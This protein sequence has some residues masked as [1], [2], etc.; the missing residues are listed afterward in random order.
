MTSRRHFLGGLMAAASLPRISWAELG[1]PAYLAAARHA[2]GYAICGISA[3]GDLRF[4]TDLP[5]RGHAATAHPTRPEA[6]AFA[7]RPGRFGLV[8]DCVTGAT[9]ARLTPPEGRQFNG[10]GCFDAEG[11]L[12]MTSEVVAE[13]SAG[14]IGLWDAMA[15]YRRIGE[16]DSGGIGPHEIRRLRSG[17]L[18]IANGGIQTDPHDRRKLN[19]DR[20]Q[21]NLTYLSPEGQPEAQVTLPPEL[22]QNSIRH[23]ALG[24]DDSVAFAMQWEG[25]PA[26]PVPL[27]GIHRRGAGLI[28]SPEDIT[29][30]MQGYAG[31]I[32]MNPQGSEIALTSPRGGT[33]MIHDRAT[34]A[35]LATH[36]RADLCGAAPGPHG[37]TLTDGLGAIWQATREGL[38]LLGK[39][40]LSWD[41][42]L[43][44]IG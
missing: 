28:L 9:R 25:D 4:T 42:H 18:V 33:V 23:L 7:R 16:W 35:P 20:M 24:P 44:S 22:S 41:N 32:A 43:I 27:L 29:G 39:T 13:G 30:A 34:A 3:A 8:L 5:A 11:T 6:I 38:T 1:S 2:E 10:H 17:G 31:S 36:R 37:F 19:I 40:D 14:R 12:L 21:P 26:I 15:G